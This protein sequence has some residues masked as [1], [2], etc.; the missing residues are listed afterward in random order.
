MN[1]VTKDTIIPTIQH[2]FA[3]QP[4][5]KAWLFGL[6]KQIVALLTEE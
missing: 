5:S 3:T 4:V 6:K 2:Y 1:N